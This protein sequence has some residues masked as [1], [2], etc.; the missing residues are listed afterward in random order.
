M[1]RL[2]SLS[3]P[4]FPYVLVRIL[5]K[6]SSLMVRIQRY[7][8]CKVPRTVEQR[9]TSGWQG[10]ISVTYLL[11]PGGTSSS[12]PPPHP[13]TSLIYLLHSFAFII[14]MGPLAD[15]SV[16]LHITMYI[17]PPVLFLRQH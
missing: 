5:S 16:C 17:S 9:V 14:L 4:R 3:V 7:N 15:S 11:L 6:G 12:P 1:D 10:A 2:L 13:P 8:V